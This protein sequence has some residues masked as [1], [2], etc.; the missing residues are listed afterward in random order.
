MRPYTLWA[1]TA[2]EECYIHM[3]PGPTG[4][5]CDYLL[6]KK[7]HIWGVDTVPT[8][9]PMNLPIGRFLPRV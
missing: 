3:H 5:F 1:G 4:A 9:H 2:D 6:E 7:I 8:D